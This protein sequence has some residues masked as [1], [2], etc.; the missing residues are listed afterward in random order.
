MDYHRSGQREM[1][2][3][4]QETKYL[5]PLQACH[6]N[7]STQTCRRARNWRLVFKSCPETGCVRI[8][9]CRDVAQIQLAGKK[10]LLPSEPASSG[11]QSKANRMKYGKSLVTAS[12]AILL[13][14]SNAAYGQSSDSDLA[15]QLSNPIASLISVPFQYNFDERYG[16]VDA[17]TRQVLNIQPVVPI[18][19]NEDWNM[20][21]RT[22]LPLINQ[23]Q[24]FPGAGDQHGL[25]DTL[26]SLFFSPVAPTPEG[27]IWGVGPVFS[28]PTASDMLLGSGKWGA[29]P[30]AVALTQKDGFTVGALANHVWSVAGDEDRTDVNNTFLQPFVSYTTS[31]A[32]T[33]TL[34]TE[35][36]YNWITEDWSV[37][38]NFNISKLVKFGSQPVSI[39]GNLRYWVNPAPGGPEGFGVRV[40]V[41]FLF[42]TK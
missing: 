18:S 4:F 12:L 9:G 15:Q 40:I 38:V 7:E 27:I 31:D 3:C 8:K 16:P 14:A 29:G 19:L 10:Y 6:T 21:S 37:P 24:L 32:W 1:E 35:S 39:G 30:T 28:I 36:N 11:I 23:S 2:F 26:Q 20:I 25:G 33:Y 17:G 5:L 41:T 34:N 42:P 22:I 13:G